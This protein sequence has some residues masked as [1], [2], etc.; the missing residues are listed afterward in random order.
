MNAAAIEEGSSRAPEDPAL[1]LFGVIADDGRVVGGQ[2]VT[3]EDALLLRMYREMKR[4][5][6]LDQ[7]MVT[8]QR[9]GRVGFYGACTGQE[10]A[11]V[12]AALAA[13]PEDWIFP[14]L[15]EN[16]I[17]L[18]RGFSLASYVAQVYGS[19]RDPLKGRQMPAHISSRSVNQVSWSSCVGTQLPQAV[20][21]AWAAHLRKDPIVTIGFLGDGATSSADF[22]AAMNFASVFQVPTVLV[23]QNNQWA[24]S[25]PVARQTGSQTIAVKARAY[26]MR[27]VRADGNDV[28]AVHG[29]M[30]DAIARARAGAGPSLIELVTYRVAPHST[31][32]D[33][34]RY[35]SNDDVESWIRKD[36]LER[37]VRYLGARGLLT[38]EADQAYE[39]EALDE[40]RKAIDEVESYGPP[41][42]STLFDDVYADLPWHL[43]EERDALEKS[44]RTLHRKQ[45][46]REGGPT[47]AAGSD[48]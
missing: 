25:V 40:I 28:V 31:S 37:L 12:G 16:A 2:T 47:G 36:P 18:V 5:R 43:A 3:V 44:S 39:R 14:A 26:G 11:V 29:V 33:P 41:E 35:R 10:A 20:G 30:S 19:A 23:C 27:G 45:P 8:L 22:H 38:P 1:G 34:S 13:A 42:R 48:T 46:A 6:L 7:R 4:V 24:I 17:M 21:A 32:D 15:R 9:Q